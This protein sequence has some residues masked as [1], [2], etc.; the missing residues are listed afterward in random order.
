[1]CC[2][3]PLSVVESPTPNVAVNPTTYNRDC[4]ASNLKKTDSKASN[5]KY[6]MAV[7]PTAYEIYE[8]ASNLQNRGRG[9]QPAKQMARLTTYKT[10][11]KVNNIQK[12]SNDHNQLN[13]L[14]LS[15]WFT[16]ALYYLINI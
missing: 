9:Y 6:N 15:R 12:D 2:R 8:K 10:D 4:E 11:V 3:A 5:L 1:M 14:H 13:S 16:A 7:N